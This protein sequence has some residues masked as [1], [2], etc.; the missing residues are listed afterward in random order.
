MRKSQI[1]EYDLTSYLNRSQ[2]E[3]P[4]PD[5]QI[6]DPPKEIKTKKGSIVF[7]HA[8]ND[9]AKGYAVVPGWLVSKPRKAPGRNRLLVRVVPL[10]SAEKKQYRV[11]LKRIIRSPKILFW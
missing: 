4:G 7:F 6:F 3:I 11:R 10:T 9:H 2:L 1:Y 8:Y 5:G